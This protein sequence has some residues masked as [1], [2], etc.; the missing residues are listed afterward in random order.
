MSSA[1][2]PASS[3]AT[4]LGQTMG[5]YVA[6]VGLGL[7]MASLGPTLNELAHLTHSPLSDISILFSARAFGGL[8]GAWL[9]GRFYDHRAGH[10]VMVRVVCIMAALA[11]VIPWVSWL[12]LLVGAMLTLGIAES[13]L[14]VGSN[15]LLVWV[16]GERVGPY[17]NALHFFFGVGAFLSP[18]IVAHAM[19]LTNN[20]TW[21]YSTLAL[22][23]LPC[24]AW[25]ARVRS[26][27][28]PHVADQTVA[29]P[30]NGFVLLLIIAFFFL[31]SSAESSFGGWVFTYALA[32]GLSDATQAAYLTAMF[33]GAL[34]VGRLL[35][36]PLALRLR[37]QTI[38]VL[39][40][41]GCLLSLVV[42][43]WSNSFMLTG[44]GALGVG[45]GMAPLFPTMIAVAERQLTITGRIT[46]WFF[47]GGSLGNMSIPWLIGQL[48][49]P[50]GPRIT[51]TIILLVMTLA[52]V[53]LAPLVWPVRKW[54]AVDPSH[55]Q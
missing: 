44:V 12:W 14:D 31:Y 45:L 47:V 34:T 54:I 3:R 9:G 2:I 55:Q 20:V 27:L 25:L 43:L 48:F 32:L 36:I 6:F 51:M 7:I 50:W 40:L 46:G 10:P 30:V 26:P 49:E 21:A 11:L 22:L 19:L 29:K 18:L 41:L 13:T 23:L 42:M 33:W 39:G 24:I 53:A 15:T 1:S 35:A 17:M 4:A 28:A 5:Y 38:L 16:H 8:I 37:A 52:G